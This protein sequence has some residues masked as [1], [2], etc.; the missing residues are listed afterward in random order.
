MTSQTI[1]QRSILD[2]VLVFRSAGWPLVLEIKI[3]SPDLYIDSRDGITYKTDKGER[4][5][6]SRKIDECVPGCFVD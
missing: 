2:S 5:R 3:K 6:E 1:S 4:D